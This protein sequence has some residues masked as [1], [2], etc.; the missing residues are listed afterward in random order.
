M[1]AGNGVVEFGV[2]YKDEDDYTA[3]SSSITAGKP[4]TPISS[5]TA[6]PS[7][8]SSGKTTSTTVIPPVGVY[9]ATATP[10]SSSGLAGTV[11]LDPNSL[12]GSL[13]MAL[14]SVAMWW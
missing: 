9:T 12:L 11:E 6:T 5:A 1:V 4:G 3:P 14:G 7:T 13:V 10:S 2:W 8:M